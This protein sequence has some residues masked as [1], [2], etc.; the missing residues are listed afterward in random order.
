MVGPDTR[1]WMGAMKVMDAAAG[2]DARSLPGL[3]V[4]LKIDVGRHQT[5]RT[6]DCFTA[7][8]PSQQPSDAISVQFQGIAIQ[9]RTV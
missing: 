2:R 1:G 9:P 7:S 3:E 5:G 8:D 4:R 6:F